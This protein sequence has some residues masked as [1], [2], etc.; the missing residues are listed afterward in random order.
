MSVAVEPQITA[1]RG[2]MIAALEEWRE[3]AEREGWD[4]RSDE[5]CDA[6]RA[7]YLFHL[8]RKHGA[9]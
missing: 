5:D 4:G 7:D 1:T 2:Q 6:A 8:L 9:S 3:T